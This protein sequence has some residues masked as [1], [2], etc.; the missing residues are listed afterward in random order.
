M[1]FKIAANF[2]NEQ[3]LQN[4]LYI[5]TRSIKKQ[6]LLAIT[7]QD[8]ILTGN[9]DESE[10]IWN[11]PEMFRYWNEML[12]TNQLKNKRFMLWLKQC[13]SINYFWHIFA[14]SRRTLPYCTC[15]YICVEVIWHT[16]HCAIEAEKSQICHYYINSWNIRTNFPNQIHIVFEM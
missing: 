11:V 12:L 3:F 8:T 4:H 7:N 2:T 10:I 14:K 5:K 6:T 13:S 15:M 16:T 1:L 9:L